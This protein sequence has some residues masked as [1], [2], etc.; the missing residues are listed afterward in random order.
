MKTDMYK[1][2]QFEWMMA[3]KGV[4]RH[5]FRSLFQLNGTQELR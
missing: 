5:R 2:A 1:C 3:A 4:E